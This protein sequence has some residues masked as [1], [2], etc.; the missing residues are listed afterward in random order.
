MTIKKLIAKCLGRAVKVQEKRHGW[1][2]LYQGKIIGTLEKPFWH[3]RMFDAMAY[4]IIMKSDDAEDDLTSKSFWHSNIVLESQKSG[5]K[6]SD[7]EIQHLGKENIT[8]IFGS[9]QSR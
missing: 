1:N 3:D 9:A 5:R 7:Y 2:I 4:T 6:F 8:L